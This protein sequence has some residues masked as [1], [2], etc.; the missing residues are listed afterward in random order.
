[1]ATYQCQKC[2]KIWHGWAQPDICS[3]YGGKLEKIIEEINK[4]K[5]KH[6]LLNS[7]EKS[8]AF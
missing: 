7:L 4:K 1:M 3:D 6:Y 5:K 2:R 8:D